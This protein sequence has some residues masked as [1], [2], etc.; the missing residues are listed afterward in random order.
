MNDGRLMNLVRDEIFADKSRR[1]IGV[2]A[3][4]NGDGKEELYLNT[5]TFSGAKKLGDRL[6]S[7]DAQLIDIFELTENLSKVNFRGQ[8]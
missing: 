3:W 5:D 6:L 2:A 4:L 8:W 1:T 7:R